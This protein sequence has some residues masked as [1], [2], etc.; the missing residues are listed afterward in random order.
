MPA[1]TARPFPPLTGIRWTRTPAAAPAI[2]LVRSFE[3]SSTTMISFV[4]PSGSSGTACT[5]SSSRPMNRSS[6]YAGMTIDS[7][8]IAGASGLRRFVA[9]RRRPI[10]AAARRT[11][12]LPQD[13]ADGPQPFP[14]RRPM[15]QRRR[16]RVEVHGDFE[17]LGLPAEQSRQQVLVAPAVREADRERRGVGY[18]HGPRAG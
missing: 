13:R 17:H 4:T 2:S 18:S 16:Q 9:E 5:S 11:N 14:R 1:R 3:Q 12:P 6:L 8:G 10:R 15:H 7:V